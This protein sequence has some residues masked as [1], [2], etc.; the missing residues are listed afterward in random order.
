MKLEKPKAE[1]IT[2][3]EAAANADWPI[4]NAS[5]LFVPGLPIK[6]FIFPFQSSTTSPAPAR[7][8][9]WRVFFPNEDPIE[10]LG[11]KL[12][13]WSQIQSESG[14]FQVQNWW[15]TDIKPNNL[16]EK[17]EL[18]KR[19]GIEYGDCKKKNQTPPNRWVE[20]MKKI[21]QFFFSPFI[22]SFKTITLLITS[23]IASLFWS[24]AIFS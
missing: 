4:L 15:K 11:V 13:P 8:I 12:L 7:G 10:N 17:S 19:K 16:I 6:S 9:D 21:Y 5:P 22:M 14:Q 18:K 24:G 23:L 20:E 1:T 2:P 3:I